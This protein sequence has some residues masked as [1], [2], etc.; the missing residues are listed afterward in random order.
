[1][2]V[3]SALAGVTDAL[4]GV[5]QRAVQDRDPNGSFVESLHE[6]HLECL[7]ELGVDGAGPVADR[8]LCDRLFDLGACS[9]ESAP[10]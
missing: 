1:M 10:R 8:E 6:R 3:T 7:R 4:L 5:T 9:R 2:V